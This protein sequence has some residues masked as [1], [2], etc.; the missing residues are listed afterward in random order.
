MWYKLQ[1][2]IDAEGGNRSFN[3]FHVRN[4]DL[5][6]LK[7]LV[8][9]VRTAAVVVLLIIN[10]FHFSYACNWMHALVIKTKGKF[11]LQPTHIKHHCTLNMS[12][13]NPS[14]SS[15]FLLKK[16]K[17]LFLSHTP[18]TTHFLSFMLTSFVKKIGNMKT[19]TKISTHLP[20]DHWFLMPC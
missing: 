16:K 12:H 20:T 1:Y 14:L 13:P 5:E 3:D 17:N 10:G 6:T 18:S 4:E 9:Y 8:T 2:F 19:R 7:V 11:S 15:T